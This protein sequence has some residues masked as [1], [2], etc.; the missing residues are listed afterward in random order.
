MIPSSQQPNSLEKHSLSWLSQPACPVPRAEVKPSGQHPYAE[1]PHS[2]GHPLK[3]A[4]FAT[5]TRSLQ[6][7]YNVSF[8]FNYQ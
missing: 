4:D 7:P 1:F 5:V 3:F 6:Q 2:N 8:K